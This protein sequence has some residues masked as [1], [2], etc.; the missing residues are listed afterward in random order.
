MKQIK[1]RVNPAIHSGKPADMGPFVV[2][3]QVYTDEGFFAL[4]WH[5][6]PAELR[7]LADDLDA[8]N[9]AYDAAVAREADAIPECEKRANRA[10]VT[11]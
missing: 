9:V 5:T 7:K 3:D 1:A 6:T 10:E 8:A 2:I 4:H 11:A